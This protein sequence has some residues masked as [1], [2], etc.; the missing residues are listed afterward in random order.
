MDKR[1]AVSFITL[2]VPWLTVPLLGKKSFVR[3]LPAATFIGYFFSILSEIAA[4]RK[5][6]KV[7][8][9]LF[10]RYRQD[11]SYL[12]GL[13][14]I[15]TLWVYKLTYKSFFKYLLLNAVIDYIFIFYIV[16]YFTKV[17][18]FEFRKMRPKHFYF[19]SI[20][21]AAIIYFY[22]KIVERVIVQEVK[23]EK[24]YIATK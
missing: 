12:L 3:F 17:R 21:M 14:F 23:K 7:K 11:F 20:T 15:V 24:E 13:F 8:N 10:P 4:D 1:K 16:K 9:A 2:V 5:W 22:Q 19:L 18:V 6:W